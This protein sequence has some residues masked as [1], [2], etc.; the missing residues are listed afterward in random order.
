MI[1]SIKLDSQIEYAGKQWELKE[2]L[3]IEM[4]AF[5]EKQSITHFALT[6]EFLLTLKVNRNKDK[7]STSIE[8][9][10]N[11]ENFQ[12]TTAQLNAIF[13]TSVSLSDGK[14]V[15]N[16]KFKVKEI[17]KE[18][19]TSLHGYFARNAKASLIRNPGEIFG[20]DIEQ[21]HLFKIRRGLS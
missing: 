20:E 17:W 6:M 19:T 5:L 8:F 16:S 4:G 13:E 18:L 11:G 14:F 12:L 2:T 9:R 3:R 1:T 10:L 15:I 7:F 21:H